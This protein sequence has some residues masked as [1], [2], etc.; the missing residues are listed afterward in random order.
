M[1]TAAERQSCSEWTG[2]GCSRRKTAGDSRL[3][4]LLQL[5]SDPGEFLTTL[6]AYANEG[7]RKLF[8]DGSF[9][10]RKLAY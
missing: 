1:D 7:P 4:K 3:G 9:S 2:T 6:L 5:P 10:T 8:V